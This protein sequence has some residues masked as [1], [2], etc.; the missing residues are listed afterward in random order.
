MSKFDDRFV[1]ALDYSDVFIIP[2]NSDVVSRSKP[3]VDTSTKIG[4]LNLEVPIISANMSSITESQTAITLWE[5]GAIGALHR[6]LS[7]EELLEEYNKVLCAQAECFVSVGVNS[8]SRTRVE[9]LVQFGA[10]YFIIDI[11]HGD[12][13][14]MENMLTWM[15]NKYGNS[16]HVMAGNVATPEGVLNLEKWGADSVKVGIGPGAVCLT[17]D[18][19]GVTVPAFTTACRCSE[20]ASVPI[21]SDGGFS[22]IGDFAKSIGAGADLCMT[23]KFFSGCTEVP[24]EVIENS[25]GKFKAYYGM[26]SKR[27]MIK[28]RDENNLPTPEGKEILVPLKGSVRGVVEDIAGGLRSAFSYVGARNLKEFQ[29]NV[30]F[31]TR[32]TV[33]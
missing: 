30:T 23:G 15:K 6:F 31:G 17:K 27:A 11:A 19:T 4:N 22:S 26:A 16:I 2:K 5:T 7:L 12:S 9:E 24:G 21:I 1:N 32:K 20:V 18:V 3:G 14:N 13:V 33:R 28:V 25:N 8:D 10:K 29:T